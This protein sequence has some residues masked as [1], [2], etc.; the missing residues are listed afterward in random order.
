MTNH[1]PCAP[2]SP[3]LAFG[4]MELGTFRLKPQV[5]E[6][7]MLAAARQ[8]EEAF[9]NNQPGL[10]AHAILKGADGVYI[11]LALADSQARAEEI[12]SKWLE[13]AHALAFLDMIDPESV[14][15]Q[16]FSRLR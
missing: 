14:L 10:L 16:F 9:L 2:S 1:L 12:C 15:M 11:D 8:M 5:S 6:A 7:Q 13:D 3:L 4:G